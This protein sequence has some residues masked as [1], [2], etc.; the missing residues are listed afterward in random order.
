MNGKLASL[1]AEVKAANVNIVTI[2]E[3]HSKRKG[4]IIMAKE[5]VIFEAIRP[6]KN[7]GT[8]CAIHEDLNPKLIEEYNNPFEL[9]VVQ[10][11]VQN[12][13]VRI[14]TGVGPQENWE[15]NKRT[16]FFI[17]LEAEVV[18]AQCT[19][20]SVI[21]QIDSIISY[22]WPIDFYQFVMNHKNKWLPEQLHHA[23]CIF[24]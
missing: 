13:S 19:G 22:L 18:K 1:N 17:A 11:E 14:M 7:G 16:P 8:L 3:T 4:K 15:E 5:F 24:T 20:K 23:W 6:S 21:I 2:Q 9:L 10:V 12:K